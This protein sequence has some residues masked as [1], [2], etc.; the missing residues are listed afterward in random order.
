MQCI[1]C[2][3]FGANDKALKNL[4]QYDRYS[5]ISCMHTLSTWKIGENSTV[6]SQV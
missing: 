3:K 4:K 5:E 1:K 6:N 2:E